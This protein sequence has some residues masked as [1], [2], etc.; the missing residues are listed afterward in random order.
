MFKTICS[1]IMISTFCTVCA[2]EEKVISG[3]FGSAPIQIG[4]GS[5]GI[6]IK[7]DPGFVCELT[8]VINGKKYTQWGETENDARSLVHKECS[9]NSGLLLCKK[10]KIT[11]KQEQK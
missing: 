4:F 8:A 9:D 7:K 11:C 3:P 6:E 2:A 10:D 5:K 1:L